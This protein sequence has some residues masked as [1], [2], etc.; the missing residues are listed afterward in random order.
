[1]F[2]PRRMRREGDVTRMGKIRDAC[3]TKVGN[4]E[5]RDCLRDTGVKSKAVPLH[6]MEAH[7]VRGD[8]APPHT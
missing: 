5:G 6:A 1:M 3:K 4:V 7:G 8:F 2:K